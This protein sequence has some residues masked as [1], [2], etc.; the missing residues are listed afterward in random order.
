LDIEGAVSPSLT[1]APATLPDTAVYRCIVNSDYG[2]ATSD[3]ATLTVDEDLELPSGTYPI[4][5]TGQTQCYNATTAIAAPV[6][7]AAFY[8]QDAQYQ[9]HQPDYS[10]SA[11]RLT[12][13]DN[14]TGLIWTRSPDWDGN[15][16]I[17]SADK[18]TFSEF[19]DY[20]QTLNAQ[21]F[22]GYSDWR[23]PTIKELYSLID[24]RGTD[25]Y[26]ESTDSSGLTPFIDTDAFAFGYGDTAAGERIIDAQ[27]WSNT[28]YVSTTMGGMA[29][30]FG[31]NFADGR[32][33]GYGRYSGPQGDM[34]QYATFVRGSTSYGT[35]SFVHNGD[36][37]VTDIATGLMWQ[38]ADSGHGMNWEDALAYAENLELAGYTDWR[39]PNAKE[40]QSLV[41]YSRSPDTTGSPAIDPLFSC[42]GITNL[43]G[44]ADFPFYW[45]GTTHISANGSGMRAAYVA[46]GRGMG[47]MNDV[48]M[49][50][51]GAGCQRSDPKDG[52][53]ADYPLAGQGPQG[54]VQR[55]FNYVRVVRDAS[56]GGQANAAPNADAG[57][58]YTVA[59]GQ[60][61]IL[62]AS[63]SAD[64]DGAIVLYEW[65]LDND[66]EYDDQTGAVADYV[67]ATAGTHTI[68]LRVTDDQGA[69]D[70]DSATVSV[71]QNGEPYD[72]YNLFC[73]LNS[74]TTYLTDIDGNVVHSWESSYTPGLSMYLLPNGELLRTGNTG[75]TA[76]AVGGAGGVVQ[77][78]AWNSDVSWEYSWST[79]ATCQHHDVEALPNGNVLMIVWQYKSGEEALAA[80]RDPALLTEGELWPDSVIE[81]KPTGPTSGDIVWEWHAWDHLVQD[82]DPAKPN[83]GDPA[84]HPERIDLNYARNGIAD[85][86]HINS[87]DYNPELDQILLSVHGFS[88]IWVIDHSTTTEEA[89]TSAGGSS[90]RGGDL[91]YRWGNAQA[92]GRGTPA[93]RMLF[94]QH[95][96]EWIAPGLPGEG[97]IL[98]FNNGSQ[99]PDGNY[100]SVDEIEPPLN[101]DGTYSLAADAPYGPATPAWTYVADPKTDFYA[102]NI[103]GAQRLPNGNTLVCDGPA[104]RFFEVTAAGDTV[105]QYSASGPVFRVERYD[106]D[107]EGFRGTPL[108]DQ[109]EPPA[110]EA[111]PQ[112]R[113]VLAGESVSFA[114]LASG[115]APLGYQWQKD[116]IDITGAKD[117]RHTVANAGDADE[118]SYTCV[119]SNAAGTAA[120]A[121]AVLTVT[122][123][124][125]LVPITLTN[126]ATTVVAFGIHPDATDDVDPAYDEPEPPGS[127]P[128]VATVAFIAP[129]N[130]TH[131][132]RDVRGAF[133]NTAWT[134]EV[135]A[136]HS[137]VP[138]TLSWNPASLPVN[139]L[140]IWETNGLNGTA[141]EGTARNMSDVEAM[142][143]PAER[144]TYYAIAANR[145]PSVDDAT[146]RIHE[147]SP[148]GTLAGTMNAEDPDTQ[149]ILTCEITD[150]DPEGVF[151]IDTDGHIALSGA[152]ALDYE[153]TP[154]YA[155]TVRVTDGGG[156]SAEAAVIITVVDMNETP[157]ANN[158]VDHLVEVESALTVG[159][160]GVLANDSDPE[161]GPLSAVLVSPPAHGFLDLAADGGFNYSPAPGF[162]GLDTF[163][164]LAADGSN[165]SSPATVNILVYDGWVVQLDTAQDRAEHSLVFGVTTGATGA[166]DPGMDLAAD[167]DAVACFAGSDDEHIALRRDMRSRE[168]GVEW[169]LVAQAAE[170][171]LTI[172]WDPDATP[173]E[174]LRLVQLDN[175]GNDLPE[176][177]I[178]M[179]QTGQLIVPAGTGATFVIRTDLD[180]FDLPLAAGWNLV[181][182][183]IRPL[184][185]AA[186]D[187]FE[188]VYRAGSVWAYA[189][190]Q[191]G[192]GEYVAPADIEPLVGYWVHVDAPTVVSIVGMPADE[193]AA[194]LQTGWNMA[195]VAAAMLMPDNPDLFG[196]AWYWDP[197]LQAYS[198]VRINEP[199]LP[200]VGYWFN[201]TAP[202]TLGTIR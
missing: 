43:A 60:T 119:V 32:I 140:I 120:S 21:N 116:G 39:L 201:A 72:G 147:N 121:P 143:A 154:A 3:P 15:G 190:T 167:D 82:Y 50:V 192:A 45:T 6:P 178:D 100:S 74:T 18:V 98:I 117:S 20:P 70:T 47:Q 173:L 34:D 113:T 16:T 65:D 148:A 84:Q 127:M 5:D 183:P 89:A 108:D 58:P 130:T 83:Y 109:A 141:V 153:T 42:T 188:S 95:D 9:G 52:D 40:L 171:P 91:L 132:A 124:S 27:F 85:W 168:P 123:G 163:T 8:G 179:A 135:D 23:T 145:A 191:S 110:I 105:W 160:P 92:Y 107:Y 129:D 28:E 17:D 170:E 174:G 159:S 61:A 88:E 162:I 195:G 55:V 31:V 73:A 157:A 139:N 37:T 165:D 62:D 177:E 166:F 103:S 126:A 97:H 99:R 33:K 66:G 54:D 181:S 137:L 169:L 80:G 155:L 87:V 118:G 69:T 186:G 185:A 38:Q 182:L 75:N 86:T 94:A 144:V 198:G 189:P 133:T 197:E 19:L 184:D 1:V 158:D 200:G 175:Q 90:G 102:Q 93:D 114:V 29:T 156:L 196:P 151:T 176:T 67:A 125:A 13:T 131:L 53:T 71:A 22:G 101:H 46:F 199:L 146:F 161:G 48:I 81:V 68:G 202:T 10:V 142:V 56:G 152:K 11:D 122:D 26:L 2:T 136:T 64:G 106:V 59:L 138:V 24:F 164:Y 79:A 187:V 76:F 112:S 14:V 7:D 149:D 194:A 193:P 35:N 115:S 128:A 30:T 44:Q 78:L 77:K 36:G 4:V 25:P 49:D 12:V 172:T 57:G 180:V 96:A 63:A 111:H 134:I 104:S 51:H 150:G 41:D